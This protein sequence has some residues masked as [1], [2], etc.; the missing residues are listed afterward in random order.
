MTQPH[1]ETRRWQN[2]LTGL[3]PLDE[4]DR[5]V[6]VRLE[7]PPL[8]SRDVAEAE[9]VEVRDVDA[10]VIAV[11]D[12]EGRARDRPGHAERATGA[13]HE[14]R[15]AGAQLARDGDDVARLQVGDELGGQLLGL[16][17][18]SALG[19]KRP[20]WTAGWAVA[21]V[22][23]TGSGGGATSRPSSSGMR[24]KSAFRT[25]SMRGV[26]RAAAGW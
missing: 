20:S 23:K 19:Q 7:V 8:R 9:E 25:S 13:A 10:S 22:R 17:G 1:R 16:F 14:R 26:Y 3:R 15:L 18:R 6:E 12:R 24:A 11:T 2:A 21:G 5:V 4:R